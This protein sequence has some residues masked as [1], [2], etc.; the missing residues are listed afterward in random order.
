[1]H[2]TGRLGFRTGLSTPACA[3]IRAISGTAKSCTSHWISTFSKPAKLGNSNVPS[4]TPSAGEQMG[5]VEVVSV[6][7]SV[8]VSVD[9]TVEATLNTKLKVMNPPVFVAVTRND[10]PYKAWSGVPEITPVLLSK[11]RPRGSGGVLE[12]E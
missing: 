2:V 12:I 3:K 7:V 4:S 5:I 8:L 10:A 11:L 9:V 1:M 6:V